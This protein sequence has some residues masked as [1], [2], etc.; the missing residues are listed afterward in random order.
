MTLGTTYLILACIGLIFT[1]LTWF[2][3]RLFPQLTIPTFVVGWLRGELAL[4][5][6]A[7]EAIVTLLFWMAGAMESAAGQVG[8][9]LTCVSWAMLVGVH[10]RGVNAGREFRAALAPLGVEPE[11]NVSVFHGFTK[12]FSFRH[13][14]V[15]TTRDL[16]Y[17]ASLP[18]DRGGRNLLDLVLPNSAEEGDRRP[19][20]LQVHGGGWLIGDKREQGRPLMTHLASRGWVCVA[21]NYRLSPEATMP[22]HVVDVKRSIAWIREHIDFFGGDPDFLCITGGSAGGH[23]SALAA[24]TPNDPGFQPGFE[25]VDTRID[26]CVPFYGV[27]DFLDRANDRPFGKMSD[28]IGP[29][30]FKCTPEENPELWDSVSPVTRVHSEAPPFFVIQGSHDSL[31]FAEEARTFVSALRAKSA[32]PVAHAELLGAQHAFEI[33]HSPRS[34][35]AVRAATAFLEKIHAEY[36]AKKTDSGR[37]RGTV[38]AV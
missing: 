11:S 30:V 4:Q 31:V 29:K 13:P 10:W 7:I 35:H 15:H 3:V 34:A 26:A 32:E 1:A 23:L 37:V 12:P 17:G 22:D 21:I 6:I 24:L 16:K 9:A 18:G 20:L 2:R 38:E 27:F 25:E 8:F 19:V 5:T 33:F 28:F 36:E 14:E